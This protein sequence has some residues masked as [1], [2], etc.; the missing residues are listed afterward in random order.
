MK[1][2]TGYAPAALDLAEERSTTG[3]G[4]DGTYVSGRQ[5]LAVATVPMSWRWSSV[6]HSVEEIAMTLSPAWKIVSGRMASARSSRMSTKSVHPSGQR[7]VGRSSPDR[8]RVLRDLRLDELELAAFEL[9]E[10]EQLVDGDVL[11]DG[12][13]RH[14]GR[15]DD[16]VH[17]EVAEERLVARVVDARDRARHV[18]VVLG[19]LAD[20]E[21][22]LIVA[23]DR[24]DDRRPGSRRPRRGGCPR[25]RRG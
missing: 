13:E 7:D 11:L 10:M 6:S 20:D 21:V 17:A 4:V 5:A 15:A 14:A 8:R 23:G 18:E 16:L 2:R 25:S 24:S 1:T 9:G 19:H 12:G 3:D 22:V